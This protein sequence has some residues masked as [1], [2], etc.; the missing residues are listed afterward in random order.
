MV[1]DDPGPNEDP[2]PT[3]TSWGE[4]VEAL[5]LG[6]PGDAF[7]PVPRPTRI[8][9]WFSL[10]GVP[11][12]EL[13]PVRAECRYA[14]ATMIVDGYPDAAAW[15]AADWSEPFVAIETG[16][17]VPLESRVALLWDDVCLYAAFAFED[18]DPTGTA[19]EHHSWVFLSDPDAELFVAGPEGY[20]ETGIN[21][22]GTVYQIRWAWLEPLIERRD[23]A[24]IE[25]LFRVPNGL[26]FTARPGE[27][28]TASRGHRI[29]E[30]YPSKGTNLKARPTTRR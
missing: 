20:V 30:S 7:G 17:A 22:I 23:H 28:S 27:R 2:N 9:R 19:R 25:R 13:L 15:A 8:P 24:A 5:A 18:P 10:A 11:D 1:T 3:E 4:T 21:P 29:V 12:G 16:D 6:D 26:Y 14:A